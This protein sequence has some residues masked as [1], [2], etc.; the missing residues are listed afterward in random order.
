MNTPL[1]SRPQQHTHTPCPQAGLV[2]Q[3]KKCLGCGL[4]S[5]QRCLDNVVACDPS[6]RNRTSSMRS[7]Q[8][9]GRST[10]PTPG[11][12]LAISCL[13][14]LSPAYLLTLAL[15]HALSRMPTPSP[16]QA[17]PPISDPL[18]HTHT[19]TRAHTH[20][21]TQ[22]VRSSRSQT[23]LTAMKNWTRNWMMHIACLQTCTN[24]ALSCCMHHSS[25]PTPCI[26][27]QHCAF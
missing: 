12:C 24:A 4:N 3:G 14:Q 7:S 22:G 9:D 2:K 13:Y 17:Y 1:P 25:G 20:T 16:N 21:H 11:V 8:V 26:S 19:H 27:I 6:S 5:H 10:L 15:P 23:C 18:R